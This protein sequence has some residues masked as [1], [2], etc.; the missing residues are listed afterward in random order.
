MGLKIGI[1]FVCKNIN[2]HRTYYL[3]QPGHWDLKGILDVM[4]LCLIP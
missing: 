2:W 3:F 1:N 4:I